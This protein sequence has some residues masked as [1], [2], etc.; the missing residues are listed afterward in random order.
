M[1]SVVTVEKSFI[2][3]TGDPVD[4]LTRGQMCKLYSGVDVCGH[5]TGDI[6]SHVSPQTSES[7]SVL[8]FLALYVAI[9]EPFSFDTT[10]SVILHTSGNM[11]RGKRR[12]PQIKLWGTPE[13]TSVFV[14]SL[15]TNTCLQKGD[16][17]AVLFSP[18]VV[19]QKTYLSVQVF[20]R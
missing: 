18:Q 15:Y 5:W 1:K 2:M 12:G 7:L 11:W 16:T 6:C 3:F 13:A 8:N 14:S 19:V 4:T 17:A 9:K 10:A 20:I